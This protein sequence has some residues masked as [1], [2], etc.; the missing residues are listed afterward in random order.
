MRKGTE[1]GQRKAR[2]GSRWRG[3]S[4]GIPPA[5]YRVCLSRGFSC[6]PRECPGIEVGRWKEKEKKEKKEK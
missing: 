5:L 1:E 4:D 2:E 3:R 6:P